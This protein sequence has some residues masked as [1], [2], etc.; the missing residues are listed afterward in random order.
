MKA[1]RHLTHI[2]LALLLLIGTAE[3]SA[4]TSTLSPE[5]KNLDDSVTALIIAKDEIEPGKKL[6]PEEELSYRKNIIDNALAL[7]LKEVSSIKEKVTG[8]T[9][10]NEAFVKIK[11]EII[12]EL[13]ELERHYREA[14]D[15]ALL[16]DTAEKIKKL[17]SEERVYRET[18]H[19][20]T[21][22]RAIDFI[23]VLQTEMLIKNAEIRYEKIASDLKKLE[24]ANLIISGRFSKEMGEAKQYIETARALIAKARSAMI[25]ATE[26][27]PNENNE[28]QEVS[29]VSANIKEK[30][31]IKEAAPSS[32]SRDLAEAAITNLKSGYDSFIKISVS[33]KRILGIR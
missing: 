20:A 5:T 32:T 33:V 8:I 29:D 9:P 14:K 6:T 26:E 31:D 4:S 27:V 10:A 30:E 21:V 15:V 12:S 23:L 11:A 28:D 22:S 25:P 1:L 17:A 19:S 18:V 16:A 13:D 24:R 7:S 2:S 3:A